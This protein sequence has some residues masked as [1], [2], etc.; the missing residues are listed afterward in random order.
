LPRGARGGLG[1]T[2]LPKNR[3][4]VTSVTNRNCARRAVAACARKQTMLERAGSRAGA[5]AIACLPA[6]IGL[7]TGASAR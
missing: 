2:A 4:R 6:W 1:E 5:F 7:A 3:F